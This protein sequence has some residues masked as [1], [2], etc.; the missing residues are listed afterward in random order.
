VIARYVMGRPWQT[1]TAAQ[2]QEYLGVFETYVVKVYTA[3][4]SSYSGEKME[5]TG[6]ERDGNGATVYSRIVDPKNGHTVSIT[7]RL[8]PAGSTLKVRDVLIENLSM[9]LNQKREFSAVVQRG[10]GTAQALI[11]AMRRKIADLDKN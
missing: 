11:D 1:A 5:I 4:L 2:R 10:G 8:R 7:W 9:S 3:Q 6:A